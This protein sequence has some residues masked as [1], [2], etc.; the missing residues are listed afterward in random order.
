MTYTISD[1]R[2]ACFSIELFKIFAYTCVIC[3]RVCPIIFDTDSMGTSCASSTVVANVYLAM[4]EDRFFFVPIIGGNVRQCFIGD[5]SVF[6]DTQ[7]HG[8]FFC[9]FGQ[10]LRS[11]YYFEFYNC[12]FYFFLIGLTFLRYMLT[13]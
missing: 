3:M 1:N 13:N 10:L 12:H 7:T 5:F 6:G 2:S 4:C 11:D 8:C 9:G